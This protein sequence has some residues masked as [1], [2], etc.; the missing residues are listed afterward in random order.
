MRHTTHLMLGK[1]ALPLLHKLRQHIIKYGEAETSRF[2]NTVS[3]YREDDKEF[4]CCISDK[5][6]DD[7]KFI[8]GVD[9]QYETYVSQE[10]VVP[11]N[12]KSEFIKDYF[13]NLYNRCLTINNPGDSS[14]MNLCIYIPLWASDIDLGFLFE[15]LSDISQIEQGY[16]IDLFLLPYDLAF[17]FEK[18]SQLFARNE[19]YVNRTKT[20]LDK[21][22]PL[23]KKYN[24]LSHLL[25]M[26]NCNSR[27]LAMG[28]DED[29]FAR[30][31]GEFALLGI[32]NYNNLFQVNA[33]D[34]E[35][36]IS[37]LGISVL[38]FDKYYFVQYLLHKAYVSILDRE[39]VMQDKVDVNKVSNIAHDILSKKVNLF[40]NF[41]NEHIEPLLNDNVPQNQIIERIK[42][43]LDNAIDQMTVDFQSYIDDPKLSL[44][45]KKATLAQLLGEDDELLSGYMFNRKQLV[46]EDCSKEVLDHFTAYNSKLAGFGFLGDYPEDL[47]AEINDHVVSSEGAPQTVSASSLLS[48]L[49]QTRIQIRESTNYIRQKSEEL[50]ALNVQKNIHR[51]SFKRLTDKGFVFDNH[52]F[53]LESEGSADIPVDG[54]Y[55]H[56]DSFKAA[57]SVDMRKDFTA[58]KNQGEMGACS[59]FALVAIFESIIKRN[60]GKDVN[61]SEQFVYFN[62]RKI[63]GSTEVDKGS[64][65]ASVLQTMKRDGVC[66]E[67]EFPYNP[68]CPEEEPPKEAYDSAL[69]NKIVKVLDVGHD[70]ENIKSA[71]TEGYP[72]A[73][74]LRIFNSFN[75]VKGLIPIPDEDDVKS[76]GGLHAMVICGYNDDYGYFVVRNSWGTNFGDNGYCYVPYSYIGSKDFLR[77]AVIVT[78][79][80]NT[81][82]KV[83]SSDRNTVFSF[84]STDAVIKSQILNNLIVLEKNKLE[85]YKEENS[86]K[87]KKFAVLFQAMGNNSNRS[88]ITNG[89][90]KRLNAESLALAQ[91]RRNLD[92]ERIAK[93]KSFDRETLMSKIW[94]WIIVLIGFLGLSLSCYLCK[95]FSPLTNKYVFYW[96][97]IP[98]AIGSLFF[99]LYLR[100]RK[101]KRKEMDRDYRERIT[102]LAQ[103]SAQRIQEAE[104][105]QLKGHLAGMIIDS[106]Y[107][108]S[109]NLRIKYDSMRSYIGNLRVWRENESLACNMTDIVK[110]PFLSVISNKVLD[111]YFQ[112]KEDEIIHDASLSRMFR[113]RYQV[114]E[115]EIVAFQN[116]LKKTIV[117][118]LN[119]Q[120]E[121][122][123]MLDYITGQKQY[124]FLSNEERNINVLLQTLDRKSEPFVRLRQ[125]PNTPDVINSHSKL[126]FLPLDDDQ[127]RREW[128]DAC[129]HNFTYRPSTCKSQSPYNIIL[130]QL[131]GVSA[132]E[133]SF[134]GR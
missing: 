123:S 31:L 120:V 11:N 24:F 124:E 109:S 99:F 17:L 12:Q 18:D 98:Y 3:Y 64:S 32:N 112:N 93:L 60:T 108:L 68:T 49:K 23:R 29:S 126:L 111:I 42:P 77:V 134:V 97:Y 104:T 82:F 40:T 37:A 86:I 92:N 129:S 90:I 28:L 36:P 131:K 80:S 63:L 125:I 88:S 46:L 1:S 91:R 83:K 113:N 51:D 102:N 2:L 58:I 72:V 55:E 79:I 73:I 74:C 94:F 130:V 54:T 117:A 115:D 53:K 81:K 41:Y 85:L 84:D 101:R 107:K 133:L 89:T 62:A 33:Q 76:G 6:Q 106:L 25:L 47:V 71:L 13:R 122:F 128:D 9:E 5:E 15:L 65:F 52:I 61:L 35:R 75:P 14:Y 116:G 100:N 34:P 103:E 132:S 110:D 30:I 78:E 114:R 19:E 21:I 96:V 27:G 105:A 44:P 67:E 48:D 4:L 16:N 59:A 70:L 87:S 7:S 121:D 39:K 45:E 26:Q 127:S 20:N 10:C 57:S 38:T 69:D 8:P 22:L 43:I 56:A 119:S 95:S 118:L 50:E 66:T